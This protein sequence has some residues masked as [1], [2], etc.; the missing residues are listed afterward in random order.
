MNNNGN[1]EIIFNGVSSEALGLI[2][3]KLPDFHRAPR[4]VTQ[5]DIPGSSV[6]VIQDE[7]GYD[8][9]ETTMEINANGVPLQDIYAWLRGEGWM[10]SSDEPDLMAYVYL[11]GQIED[12]RFRVEGYCYDNLVIPIQ[13]EPYL[14]EV[15]EAG[16]TLTTAGTF[17]GR[18]HDPALPA[19]TV[20]G[21]G[22]INLLVNGA[23]VL[24]DGLSGSITIDSETGVAYTGAG[25][26]MEWAGSMVSLQEGDS[27]PQLKPAGETNLVNWSGTVTSVVIQPKWRY[28]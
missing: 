14:R 6:P 9:Y 10:I 3:T 27:W 8:P 16:I 20:T 26:Q 15:D 2:V 5:T 21:T 17:A 23:S 1:P 18:G 7:G 13:T 22:D 24:I 19:I 11:Y 28:L 12:S 25:D 4:R